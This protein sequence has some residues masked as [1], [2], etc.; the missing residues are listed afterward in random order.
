MSFVKNFIE[1]FK[2]KPQLDEHKQRPLFQEREV[3]MCHLGANI[4]FEIDGKNKDALRPAIVFKKLSGN[5]LLIIPLTSSL[6]NGSWYSPSFVKNQE[7]RYCLNQI[8][9]IDAKRL[10]YEIERIDQNDFSRLRQ[11]FQKMIES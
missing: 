6:K 8:K 7:G 10:K 11:D 4:G 5:T 9:M 3:W 2:L 1:W